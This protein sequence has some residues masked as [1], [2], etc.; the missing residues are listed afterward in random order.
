LVLLE[1]QNKKISSS[2]RKSQEK[3]KKSEKVV[4]FTQNQFKK[5]K[6]ILLFWCNSKFNNRKPLIFLPNI[7]ISIFHK[8]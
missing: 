6:W 7:Y 8:W 5:K 3:E 4:I 1:V 2:F